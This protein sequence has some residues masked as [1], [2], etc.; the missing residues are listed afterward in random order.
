MS[1][2]HTLELIGTSTESWGDA[3]VDAVREAAKTIDGIEAL[4]VLDRSAVVDTGSD[5]EWPAV[6][7]VRFRVTDT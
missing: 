3:A 7:R 5:I 6:V 2:I 4:E 1:V